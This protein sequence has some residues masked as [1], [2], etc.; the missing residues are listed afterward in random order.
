LPQ[1]GALAVLLALQSQALVH[2]LL[3]RQTQKEYRYQ[4]VQV[5]SSQV[6]LAMTVQYLEHQDAQVLIVRLEHPGKTV[7]WVLLVVLAAL[8]LRTAQKVA[9]VL[10]ALVLRTTQKVAQVPARWV[11]Q[12]LMAVVPEGSLMVERPG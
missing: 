9:Q 12:V 4:V 5:V 1:Q 8:V 11:F 7:P 2:E 3:V 10:A 6:V